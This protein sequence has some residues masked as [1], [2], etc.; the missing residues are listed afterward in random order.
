[1]RKLLIVAAAA[2]LGMGR[3]PSS[4]ADLITIASPSSLLPG[5][6]SYTSG[7][8]VVPIPG[9]VFDAISSVSADGVTVSFDTS[10]VIL[11][12]PTT[13]ASW[14]SPP[15]SESDT[16]RVLW[17]NG[18]T[19]LTLMFSQ[20][21]GVFG[22]EVQ[23]NTSVVSSVTA[24]F[25]NGNTLL[26]DVSLDVD[27]NGGARL[28]AAATTAPTLPF[29]SVVISSTDDFAIAQ[30]RFAPASVPE[31]TSLALCGLGLAGAI[32]WR[33]RRRAGDATA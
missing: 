22:V 3:A 33:M 21:L 24:S 30:L 2:A 11:D 16:P 12:V 10:L 31:P 23:P 4:R 9:S 20:P 29:T 7:T 19:S 6:G 18:F 13:W 5:G 32:G 1:M 25:Y 15:S 8:T 14:S 28:F 26:G 17:T 27:G